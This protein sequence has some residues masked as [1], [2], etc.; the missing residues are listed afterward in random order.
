MTESFKITPQ[1]PRW[2]A[3][4]VFY[5]IFPDRFAVGDPAIS[6]EGSASWDEAPTRANFFGG[7]LAGITEHLDH[8]VNL[9][10]NAIYLTPIFEADRNHRYDTV[11]HRRIDHRLGDLA[12]FR[13]FVASAHA[14]GIRVV[15]DA[16]FNHVGD[17]HWAFRHVLAHGPQSPYRDWFHFGGFPVVRDP[18]PN[19]ATCLEC[20]Y[21]PQL[22]HANPEVRDYLLDV[23]RQWSAEGIDGWRLDVPFLMD[24]SFWTEFRAVVKGLDPE[25]YIVAEVW[26]DGA[27]WLAGDTADG[28]MN[29]PLRDMVVGFADGGEPAEVFADRLRTRSAAAPNWAHTSLLNLLGSHDTERVATRLRGDPVAIRIAVALQLT[30]PGAPMIYYGDE[31]GMTGGN[32]PDCRAPMC[33]DRALWDVDLLTWHRHLISLRHQRAELR[34]DHDEIVFARGDVLVRCRSGDS[35]TL[36]VVVNRSPVPAELPAAV[37]GGAGHD[38]LTGTDLSV[39]AAGNL[40]VPGGSV[41]IVEPAT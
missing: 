24:R 28:T 12:A 33:W 18:V 27:E 19:Y 38:L 13:R 36:F 9:G 20:K 2:V 25:L 15:L 30:S 31:I 37:V 6:P 1:A 29:Y 35:G 23:T 22:N 26:D 7:D 32:D 8:I 4:A 11:D 40:I 10:A 17:G 5:Q 21:L 14:R 34:G 39:D 16:V 41:M 3:D